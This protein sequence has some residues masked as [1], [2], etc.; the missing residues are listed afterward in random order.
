MFIP[1]HLDDS[2]FEEVIYPHM[3]LSHFKRGQAIITQGDLDG[4][5]L[6]VIESG[7]VDVIVDFSK[8]DPAIARLLSSGKSANEFEDDD[9]V[10]AYEASLAARGI[11]KAGPTKVK[12]LSTGDSFGEL[13]IMYSCPR[14]ATCV[15]VSDVVAWS[16]DGISFRSLM[17]K[18]MVAT[19]KSRS[20]VYEYICICMYVCIY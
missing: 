10:E 8:Q 2:T 19:R 17:R 13:A 11:D 7:T 15:A 14:Q 1:K 6:F 12:T 5:T 18:R 4:N 16:L 3:S 9:G 20:Q